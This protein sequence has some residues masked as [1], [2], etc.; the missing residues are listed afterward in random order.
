MKKK[1][2]L[3]GILLVI[4]AMIIMQLPRSEADAATSASDFKME[5]TTLIKYVG[6]EKIVSVPATVEV[7]GEN[8]FDKNDTIEKVILPDS[9]KSIEAYAFW[10]C[11]NLNTVVLG[12]GLTEVGD[13][14]F[15]NCKGLERMTIPK[16]IRSIGIQAFVDCVNMTDITIPPEVTNIHDTAFNGCYRL[17]IHCDTGTFADKYAQAF[18]EKQLEM[19]EYEDVADYAPSDDEKDD[20]TSD[21]DKKENQNNVEIGELMGSTS[22]VGNQAVVFIDNTSPLMQNNVMSGDGAGNG[23][24]TG[25]LPELTADA[26]YTIVDGKIVADQ[27]YYR[28]QNLSEVVLSEGIEEIGQ[29]AYARSSLSEITIPEGTQTI[30]YGAFYHCDD[31]Q[32]IWLPDSITNIEPK[33]FTHSLYW[34]G[35]MQS[36]L[37]FIVNGKSLLA[38]NEINAEDA[39]VVTIPEGVTVIAGEV[40]KDHEHIETVVLP[41]S[42][43]TIGEG[44]FE[45]CTN[46]SRVIWAEEGDITVIKDRAFADCNLK[47]VI[48][49]ETVEE[50]GI[51]AFDSNVKVSYAGNTPQMTHELSAER[52]SNETYR[53]RGDKEAELG[54]VG[55]IG[56]KTEGILDVT[57]HLEGA[58]REYL[59][60]VTASDNISEME[61]AFDR[62]GKDC[63][64]MVLYDISLTDNS[65]ILITKLGKQI[66]TVTLPVD[67]IF[68][69]EQV[70]V[71]TLDRNGQL[72]QLPATRVKINGKD[73]VRFNTT[74][75]SLFGVYGDGVALNEADVMEEVHV[76]LQQNA[77]NTSIQ[78]VGP[79][80]KVTWQWVVGGSLLLLGAL[81]IFIKK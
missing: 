10:G 51:G 73:Y 25:N 76:N 30:G 28:N 31:L 22:V 33:A 67:T 61:K 42:L 59:L 35:I 54:N 68:A 43:K 49:P 37:L 50:L 15:A 70:K 80:H 17:V 44:A 81:C 40:F 74:H 9:V 26:K 57:A 16:N 13:F 64:D 19:P 36:E 52:L 11:D 71:V 39:T 69:G 48:L 75:L 66:L 45:G 29:F 56:V 4:I 38:Y 55:E 24:S 21:S 65:D 78:S 79:L 47:K 53:F 8:A 60:T 72:E 77:A 32:M 6:T 3:F 41:K 20:N 12:K 27:A 7:I 58:N 5:G 14:V 18:Y 46:L 23:G 2:K 62:I 1:R 63:P 34:D